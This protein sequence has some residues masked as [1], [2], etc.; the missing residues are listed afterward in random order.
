LSIGGPT[1]LNCCATKNR[2]DLPVA[3]DVKVWFRRNWSLNV[4]SANTWML[5]MPLTTLVPSIPHRL[6]GNVSLNVP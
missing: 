5:S 2:T 6:S 1:L 4:S 3:A